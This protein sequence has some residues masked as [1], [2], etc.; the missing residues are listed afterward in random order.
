MKSTLICEQ[1]RLPITHFPVKV[2]LGKFK[3]L[4]TVSTC[5]NGPVGGRLTFIVSLW[6]P[7][8]MVWADTRCP[9]ARWNSVWNRAAVP[10][11]SVTLATVYH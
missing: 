5:Q 7:L 8:R 10:F 9:V 11:G 6:S 2:V 1:Q 4:N 3:S